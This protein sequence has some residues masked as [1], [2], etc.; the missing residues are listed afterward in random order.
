MEADWEFE[1]GGDAAVIDACWPGLVDLRLNPEL[2]WDLP[3]AYQL[4]G[5]A[6]ALARLNGA[7]SPVWTSKC[8]VWPLTE[9][10]AFDPDELRAPPDRVGN[11]I[12][13]YIDLIPR[14]KRWTVPAGAAQACKDL[15]ALLGTPPLDCCRVDL[16]IRR[17]FLAAGQADLG[18]TAYF[19]S[20]GATSVEAVKTLQE[21][22]VAFAGALCAY[23][24]VE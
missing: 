5:L 15:C 9:A 19:I 10:D 1:V 6:K 11:A 16:V 21:A 20:C 18:I 23:S 22:L 24:T 7:D 8:D 12:G 14:E 17:A 13:C 2:A 3:E 4:P